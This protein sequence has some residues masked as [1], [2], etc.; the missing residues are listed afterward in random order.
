[1]V[2]QILTK[3]ESF[4]KLAQYQD[5]I[6]QRPQNFAEICQIACDTLQGSCAAIAFLDEKK[7]WLPVWYGN[8]SGE[9]PRE[10]SLST[11]VMEKKRTII[12]TDVN[13]ISDVARKKALKSSNIF[14]YIAVPII[15]E[16]QLIIGTFFIAFDHP[17]TFET[18]DVFMMEGLSKIASSMLNISFLKIENAKELAETKRLFD[19]VQAQRSKL[20]RNDKIL[21][22]VS[23]L[24]KVGG[25]EYDL[26]KQSIHWSDQVYEIHEV[27]LGTTIEL[28]SA[29][30]FYEPESR[31]MVAQSMRKTIDTGEPFEF[32]CNITTALGNMRAVKSI[33]EVEYENNRAVR[34]FGTFQDITEQ[35]ATEAQARQFLKME[36][37]GQLTG[38]ISHDFNNIL[39]AIIG[40]LQFYL[41]RSEALDDGHNEVTEALKS[42]Q[43]GVKLTKRLLDFARGKNL[44]IEKFDP[45][46]IVRGISDLMQE[47]CGSK[48]KLLL[49]FESD[50]G[51]IATDISMF[52]TSLLNLLINS[53]D[54]SPINS[55]ITVCVQNV[56][57]KMAQNK[58]KV[59]SI[60]TE[61]IGISVSDKGTGMPESVLKRI[62]EPFFT[63]K[64]PGK[65][66]GL[67]LCIVHNLITRSDGQLNIDSVEGEGTT[68]TML[69]PRMEIGLH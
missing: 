2:L 29:L 32:E 45:C 17:K 66:T 49:E 50:G 11:E 34:V 6:T 57:A 12:V 46:S 25:W 23:K 42:A 67:G 39:S 5:V 33:G 38:E 28:A 56:G 27:M 37:L 36:T 60:P 31:A 44:L 3:T 69:L 19:K 9:L 53:R 4:V 54:A 65:G 26:I 64:E 62:T 18:K 10:A 63:T 22:H 68:V 43:R 59:T 35:R 61:Y 8:Y 1:V 58:Y 24:A 15:L 51:A 41:R 20:D 52:E 7:S 16:T 13:T 48:I 30:H 47:A 21:K 55:E 40:N 14:S